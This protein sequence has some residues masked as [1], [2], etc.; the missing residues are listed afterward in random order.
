MVMVAPKKQKYFP[1]ELCQK[2]TNVRESYEYEGKTL[3]VD[4]YRNETR[5][6]IDD[7]LLQRNRLKIPKI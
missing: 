2:Q 1:C 5:R 3:C 6:G 4:C 7:V